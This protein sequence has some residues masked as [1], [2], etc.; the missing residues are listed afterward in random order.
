[1]LFPQ[2]LFCTS[3]CRSLVFCLLCLD[4]KT[5]PEWKSGTLERSLC[6]TQFVLPAGRAA[7]QK[8]VM[9][10]LRRIEHPT[11]GNT[12]VWTFT[13]LNETMQNES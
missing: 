13:I 6:L 8:R 2:L 10:L 5:L 4:S 3:F 9:A 11:A 1:M 7:L 12:E